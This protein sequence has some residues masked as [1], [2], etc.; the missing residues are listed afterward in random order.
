M[1]RCVCLVIR[2]LS[3]YLLLYLFLCGSGKG[4]ILGCSSA[5]CGMETDPGGRGHS[6]E[7]LRTALAWRSWW[8]GPCH[9][10]LSVTPAWGSGAAG[11]L[12][13]GREE[14]WLPASPHSLGA[15]GCLLGTPTSGTDFDH[16]V[17]VELYV[18]CTSLGGTGGVKQLP[19]PQTLTLRSSSTPSSL[20]P[21]AGLVPLWGGSPS[22]ACG[23]VP[24][25]AISWRAPGA[26]ATVSVGW[27][28]NPQIAPVPCPEGQASA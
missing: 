28:V 18:T 17:P 7:G 2:V 11:V 8:Q 23:P 16:L 5:Q 4:L 15:H 22:P 3:I 10:G 12:W 19:A 25:R 20:E 1:G 14:V 21:T 24:L 9:A 13:C 6:R 26:A 27:L